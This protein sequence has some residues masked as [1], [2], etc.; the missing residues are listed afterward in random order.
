M[1]HE[2]SCLRRAFPLASARARFGELDRARAAL[3]A[4]LAPDP[5]FTIRR[6]HAGLR[7]PHYSIRAD[8]RRCFDRSGT[9][10]EDHVERRLGRAAE[11]LEAR[12]GRDLTQSAFTRLGAEPQAHFLR[13]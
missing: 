1:S 12:F 6:W 7:V 5:T 9:H 11:A 8:V 10:F 3:Q 4:G 2:S 13:E